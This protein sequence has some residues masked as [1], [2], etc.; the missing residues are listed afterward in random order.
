MI[1]ITVTSDVMEVT[2]TFRKDGPSIKFLKQVKRLHDTAR[3]GRIKPR[4]R[5]FA[6]DGKGWIADI[7][8][9]KAMREWR[10]RKV[11]IIPVKIEITHAN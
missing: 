1:V 10:Q 4:R 9:S 5:D 2:R 7:N 11:K 3:D 6:S 8:F